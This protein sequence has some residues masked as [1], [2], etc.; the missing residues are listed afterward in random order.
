LTLLFTFLVLFAAGF[1]L[2]FP[3]EKLYSFSPGELQT[4][5]SGDQAPTWTRDDILTY[6]EPKLGYTKER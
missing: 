2:V 4:M 3:I 5:V 6:T 1:D